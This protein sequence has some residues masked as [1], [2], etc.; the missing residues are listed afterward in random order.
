MRQSCDRGSMHKKKEVGGGETGTVGV[1][2]NRMCA[3]QTTH[4]VWKVR[5]LLCRRTLAHVGLQRAQKRR[6]NFGE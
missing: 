4:K 5:R 1:V 6:R 2:Q 3:A